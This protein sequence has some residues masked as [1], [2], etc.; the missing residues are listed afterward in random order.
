[1][2][3]KKL[4]IG[5][6]KQYLVKDSSKDFHTKDGYIKKKDLKK[7]GKVK[8]NKGKEFLVCKPT[9]ADVYKKMHRHAQI[10]TLK[11]IGMIIAQC[12]ITKTTV[13]ADAG[14]GS[15]ATA[16]FLGLVAKKVI[17]YD[18]DER[19]L[20]T[21]KKNIALLGLKNVTIKKKDIY[22]DGKKT[23][24]FAD[25]FTLDVPQPWDALVNVNHMLKLG[26]FL[27]SYSPQITQ[28]QKMVVAAEKLGFVHDKSIE[29]IERSWI[30]DEKRARPG[31]ES[32]GHTG[33]LSFFRKVENI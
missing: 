5:K 33:F 26:G 31:F 22:K 32:L 13:V 23:K 14:S 27:V 15:G 4:L 11:D 9:M 6:E 10:M 17:T 25:V 2:V 3:T 18:I 7:T 12:G 8:T 28:S 30:L 19:S 29:T 20:E 16:C 24:G 1:M 21:T